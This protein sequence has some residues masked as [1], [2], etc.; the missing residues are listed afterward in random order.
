VKTLSGLLPVCA[1]RK[2][3]R[4]DQRYWTRVETYLQE[5]T[6][7]SFTHGVCPSCVRVLFPELDSS[8]EPRA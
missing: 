6:G 1:N 2:K 5:R 4:D 7:V 8:S 3:I